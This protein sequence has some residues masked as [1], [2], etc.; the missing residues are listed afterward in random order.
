MPESSIALNKITHTNTKRVMFI[1]RDFNLGNCINTKEAS[2]LI[3][4]V[5]S[6]HALGYFINCTPLCE[7]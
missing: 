2:V 6:H 7:L 4:C 1:S 3:I 5:K